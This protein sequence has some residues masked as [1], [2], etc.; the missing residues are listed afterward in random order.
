[1]FEI[2]WLLLW[3]APSQGG[4]GIIVSE[5]EKKEDCLNA[6][7][8]MENIGSFTSSFNGDE[9]IK[10]AGKYFCTPAPIIKGP[11]TYN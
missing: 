7:L 9:F 5:I 1:M 4:A 11:D 3:I 10:Y 2:I 8:K 6:I